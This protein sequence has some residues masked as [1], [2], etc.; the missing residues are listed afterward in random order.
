M[1]AGDGV[2]VAAAPP[3]D[4]QSAGPSAALLER[5][6]QHREHVIASADAA[7]QR[8]RGAADT[9]IANVRGAGETESQRVATAAADGIRDALRAVTD[10][11]GAVESARTEQ[12]GRVNSGAKEQLKALDGAVAKR[13]GDVRKA[14]HTRADQAVAHGEKEAERALSACRLKAADAIVLGATKAEAFKPTKRGGRKARAAREIAAETSKE[15][16]KAGDEMA[17]T[18]RADAKKLA[19]KFRR[20]GEDAAKKLSGAQLN[21]ARERIEG[22]R[23]KAVEAIDTAADQTLAGVRRD[24]DTILPELRTQQSEA[25]KLLLVAEAAVRAVEQH[26]ADVC[27]AIERRTKEIVEGL[28]AATAMAENLAG[29]READAAAAIASLD[30]LVGEVDAD[31]DREATS[32]HE[33]MSTATANAG[34]VIVKQAGMLTEPVTQG[35]TSFLGQ[36]AKGTE[37]TVNGM[38]SEADDATGDM[39]ET[40]E[41]VDG[42]LAKAV[43][44]ATSGWDKELREGL[45]EIT[46]KVDDGV[47]KQQETLDG[48]GKKIDERAQE[49]HDESWWSRAWSFTKGLLGGFLGG[50]WNMVTFLGKLVLVVIAVVVVALIVGAIIGGLAG[51]LAVLGAIAAVVGFIASIGT[52]LLV[53]AVVIVTVVVAFRIYRLATDDSLTDYERGELV[54]ESLFDVGSLIFGAKV[55][56]WLGGLTTAGA[57]AQRLARLRK[58][59]QN[60][61]LLGLLLKLGDDGVAAEQ[62]V[63]KLGGNVD[64][65]KTLLVLCGDDAVRLD[66]LLRRLGPNADRAEDLLRAAGADANKVDDALTK[67][68]DDVEEAL[69]LLR[70][71]PEPEPPPASAADD[72]A[73][74]D[75]AAAAAD[76][77]AKTEEPPKTEPERPPKTEE[78]PKTEP[79]Q[80]PKTE[81][82]PKTEPEQPPKTEEP[83]AADPAAEAR[84]AKFKKQVDDELAK[85]GLSGDPTFKDLDRLTVEKVAKAF[86]S[87]PLKAGKA[88]A[89]KWALDGARGN[90]REFANRYEYVKARFL[91]LRDQA[92][93]PGAPGGPKSKAQAVD[94][95]AKGTT[96]DKLDDALR[97]DLAD[98]AALGPGGLVAPGSSPDDI[99]AA[100]QK[101]DRVAFET[102]TAEAYHAAKHMKDVPPMAGQTGN[103]VKD[104]AAAAKETI[105][106]GKIT[107]VKEFK[108]PDAVRVAIRK[109]LGEPPNQVEVEA[110]IYVTPDGMPTLA[111]FGKPL[112]AR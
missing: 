45:A 74:G 11:E 13:Q 85:R 95:A 73:K 8:V 96:T 90:P 62:L 101:L 59:L 30:E 14:A 54:G 22:R 24:R 109:L 110:V 68:G 29:L 46:K 56:K 94:E 100:V 92:M 98:V 65:L 75:D 17:K 84:A 52:F 25:G 71:P 38:R 36:V 18:A 91:Y 50:L 9:E 20:E 99:A 61:E 104:Y 16:I 41:A 63:A 40:F 83:P 31:L 44:E 57:Q 35:V 108:N 93:K 33:A 39:R 47:K 7:K 112:G 106:T 86:E 4:L 26:H 103:Y 87:D 79:E 51:V 21:K 15:M 53:L 77:A 27:D 102:P 72:A 6:A 66:G 58:L 28:D 80:P 89:Q 43:T 107:S 81:E 70:K 1:R 97:D 82:A 60:D 34:E 23:A 105:Q 42:E 76:D 64:R 88:A 111:T 3:V 78:P 12:K 5:I 37:S 19:D 69:K 55:A 49:I 67:A 32:A 2:P 48:L 10:A